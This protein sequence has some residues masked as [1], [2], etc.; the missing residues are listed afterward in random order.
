MI[1]T[2]EM[3][4]EA[5]TI[6]EQMSPDEFEVLYNFLDSQIEETNEEDTRELHFALSK[7]S[8]FL[9]KVQDI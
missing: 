4:L 2:N 5:K 8:A 6:L 3:F 7:L 9:L 1:I